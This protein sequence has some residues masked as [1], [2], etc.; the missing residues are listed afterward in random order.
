MSVITSLYSN[1]KKD[2]KD[3]L[4][5]Y[6]K[7]EVVTKVKLIDEKGAEIVYII[8]KLFEMENS[9][10]TYEGKISDRE[11]K[12]D[13]EKFPEKLQVIIHK[14]INIHLKNME[15]ETIISSQRTTAHIT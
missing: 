11:L 14:F 5:V 2:I 7:D 6:E 8:I 13:L 15:E 10:K 3:S 9:I 12:F 4:T 1:L